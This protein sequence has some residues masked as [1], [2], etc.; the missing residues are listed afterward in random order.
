MTPRLSSYWL[1]FI[2][3]TSYS[4]AKNLVDSMKVDVIARENDLAEKLGIELISYREA[5]QLAF[6]KIKQNDVLSSWHDSFNEHF[7]SRNIWQYIEVPDEGCYKDIKKRPV[8]NEA[9]SL[10]RIFGIGGSAGWYYGNFLWA[11]RGHIDR[12]FGGVGASRGRRHGERLEPGDV[13]D[14][15]RVLYASR[16]EKR[17]L[18]FAEMKLPGEAWLEFKIK[19]GNLIQTAT[20]RPVGILG[21]L[22]W[23]SMLPFHYF[24]FNGMINK[25]VKADD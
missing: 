10:N 6:D 16:E 25:L 20:Y 24:I 1:Y 19:N 5:I 18:L 12:L 21:R 11:I 2:S 17:L 15:W 23:Y 4:L 7:H 22:Y 9:A 8:T 14:F 3:S 13:V